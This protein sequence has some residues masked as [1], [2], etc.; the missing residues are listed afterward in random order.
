MKE[1]DNMIKIVEKIIEGVFKGS[2]F[3]LLFM[4]L[5]VAGDLILRNLGKYNLGI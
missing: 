3:P 5:L 1:R 2:V 4:M